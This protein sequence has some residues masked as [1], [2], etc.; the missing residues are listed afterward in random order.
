MRR[1][2]HN[3][4]NIETILKLAKHFGLRVDDS[5]FIGFLARQVIRRG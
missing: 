4:P 2:A 5:D 1:M 3:S